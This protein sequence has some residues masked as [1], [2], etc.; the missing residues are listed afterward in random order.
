MCCAVVPVGYRERCLAVAKLV[1]P[2][3]MPGAEFEHEV[4]LLD[5]LVRDFV[6]AHADFLERL[7]RAEQAAAARRTAPFSVAEHSFEAPVRHA[8][9]AQAL[10]YIEGHLADPGLS[11]GRVARELAV[12]ANYL[13]HLFVA[14]LGWRMRRYIVDKRIARAMTL[15]A[16]TEWQVKRIAR[17]TGHANPTWFHHVFVAFT[18]VSPCEY[19][20]QA[21]GQSCGAVRAP[22]DRRFLE[23]R[24]ARG[25]VARVLPMVPEPAG[26]EPPAARESPEDFSDQLSKSQV[27]A[28]LAGKRTRRGA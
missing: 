25:R 1:C 27:G 20:A 2:G 10:R 23:L 6:D 21:C 19:R 16:T 8:L 12:H 17:E 4:E 7:L 22:V 24:S 15:L 9:V 11:V 13:S 26:A 18:G 14:Q 28:V 3:P 5:T